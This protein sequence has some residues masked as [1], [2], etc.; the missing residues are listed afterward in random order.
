LLTVNLE[1]KNA[2]TITLIN[3]FHRSKT[4]RF[5]RALFVVLL[6]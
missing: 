4:S 5:D 1:D 2:P 6:F 3:P